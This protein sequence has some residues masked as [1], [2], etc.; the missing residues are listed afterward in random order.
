MANAQQIYIFH[1][2]NF[3]Q[4]QDLLFFL[5]RLVKFHLL[6]SLLSIFFCYSIRNIELSHQHLEKIRFWENVTYVSNLQSDMGWVYLHHWLLD[7]SVV[8]K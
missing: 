7:F 3:K 4:H 8:T 5:V 2:K 1:L 6:S